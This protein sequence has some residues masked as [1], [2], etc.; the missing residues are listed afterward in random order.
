MKK[1]LMAMLSFAVMAAPLA[2]V[3][4]QAEAKTKAKHHVVQK[5]K[6]VKHHR[7]AAR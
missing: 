3:S 2:L 6:V 7:H 1:A 4:T 5:H